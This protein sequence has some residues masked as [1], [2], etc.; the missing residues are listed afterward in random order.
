MLSH[1]YF[2]Y[3]YLAK[4]ANL[5]E[6]SKKNVDKVNELNE[7]QALGESHEGTTFLWAYKS[8]TIPSTFSVLSNLP[9]HKLDFTVNF[10]E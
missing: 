10:Q 6:L 5:L 9:A 7:L 2:C 3:L 8:W 1:F 4:K